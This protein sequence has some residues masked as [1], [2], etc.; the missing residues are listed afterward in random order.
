M[1]RFRP[2]AINQPQGVGLENA[3]SRG[4][5][6]A[7]SGAENL[8]PSIPDVPATLTDYPTGLWCRDL[9]G[10]TRGWLYNGTIWAVA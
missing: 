8:A 1:R 6:P 4:M 3:G 7:R 9:T 5:S 10:A 2:Q